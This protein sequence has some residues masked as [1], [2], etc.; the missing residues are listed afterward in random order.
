MS[1][2]CLRVASLLH[3]KPACTLWVRQF[4]APAAEQGDKQLLE[5]AQ[6]QPKA[7][8]APAIA[9]PAMQPAD[10]YQIR[11]N[12]RGKGLEPQVKTPRAERNNKS[13]S[14]VVV[15]KQCLTT[16]L[17]RCLSEPSSIPTKLVNA[18]VCEG[19]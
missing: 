1:K 2:V 16:S 4:L 7:E 9:S 19:G 6:S 5:L 13:P 11:H 10:L 12:L 17:T 14:L 3:D 18:A 8:Q 15:L